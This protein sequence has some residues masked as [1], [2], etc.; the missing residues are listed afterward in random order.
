MLNRHHH[1]IRSSLRAVNITP[2]TS[3]AP[4]TTRAFHVSALNKTLNPS[5]TDKDPTLATPTS[6]QTHSERL[7]AYSDSQSTPLPEKFDR[8]HAHS[9]QVYPTTAGKTVSALQGHFQQ[10]LMR[11]TKPKS[12]L[13]LGTF[14][15]YSAMAMA[16][17]MPKGGVV[18]TCEKDPKAAKLSRELFEE[19]A[20]SP[21]TKNES[22]KRKDTTIEVVEGDG[23]SS[24]AL[25]LERNLRFDAVFLDADKGGYVNYYN[26]ILDNDMLTDE[27]YILADNV[28]FSGLVLNSEERQLNAAAGNPSSSSKGK[29]KKKKDAGDGERNSETYQKF[30]DHIHTFNKH[31]RNDPRVD[32][33]VLPVFDGLSL[34][35]KKRK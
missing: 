32:V 21:S 29:G 20:Y 7:F 24:L 3:W 12:V 25:L 8:L 13:E 19:H 30:A 1:L 17:G 4:S 31:V 10:M 5:L 9:L 34:I 18:Y 26:F 15:G 23:L 35:M 14:M 16:D 22:V 6:E 2:R 27:G 33:V 28:L 11:L